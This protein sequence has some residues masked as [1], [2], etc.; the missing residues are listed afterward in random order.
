MVPEGRAGRVG[1]GGKG[2]TTQH[3]FFKGLAYPDCSIHSKKK[4]VVVDR[5]PC[6]RLAHPNKLNHLIK[7][8][9]IRQSCLQ[10]ASHL[11]IGPFFCMTPSH[12][13]NL[14]HLQNVLI[15]GPS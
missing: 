3:P 2:E 11:I 14:D 8:L 1:L 6:K 15:T 12:L 5:P 10:Q 7:D 13:N 9:K 4:Y